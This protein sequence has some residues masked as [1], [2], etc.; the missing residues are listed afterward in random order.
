MKIVEKLLGPSKLSAF[1]L[2]QECGVAQPTLSRWLRDAKLVA[3]KNKRNAG[4]RKRWSPEEKLRVI[5]ATAVA[6]D[7]G[8]GEVLRAEGL[9]DENLAPL[10]RNES[11]NL[12][13]TFGE[14]RKP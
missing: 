2:S 3:V 6:G 11:S 5:L 13:G 14:R 8:A 1:R 9:H 4:T 7:A 10:I 12:S